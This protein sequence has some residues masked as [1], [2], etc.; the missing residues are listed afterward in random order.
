LIGEAI[1]ERKN[2]TQ[3]SLHLCPGSLIDCRPKTPL[4]FYAWVMTHG[5]WRRANMSLVDPPS[6][7]RRKF[8]WGVSFSGIR[9][10]SFVLGV[11]C[12]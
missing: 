8:S 2:L 7:V 6:G 4:S 12:L 1:E 5:Y 10:V 11:R 9:M 3:W